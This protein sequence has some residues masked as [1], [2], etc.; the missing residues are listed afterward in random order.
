[1][2]AREAG[3]GLK[4]DLGPLAPG[5]PGGYTCGMSIEFEFLAICAVVAA[6]CSSGLRAERAAYERLQRQRAAYGRE[7]QACTAKH[8][9]DRLKAAW[10]A[11]R[12]REES[13]L[14][15]VWGVATPSAAA[16]KE[17]QEAGTA[18]GAAFE[19]WMAAVRYSESCAQGAFDELD[20]RKA[21]YLAACRKCGVE[22]RC[23]ANALAGG[24]GIGKLSRFAC[25]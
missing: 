24:Y 4:G 8:G 25:E 7:W 2:A 21:E 6:G 11:A 12:G 16:L 13:A 15:A 1:M 20:I 5:A 22:E 14:A 17:Q 10:E 19:A 23:V 9:A 18:R 3:Q